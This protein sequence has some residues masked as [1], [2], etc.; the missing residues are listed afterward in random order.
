MHGHPLSFE[1]RIWTWMQ[2]HLLRELVSGRGEAK[3]GFRESMSRLKLDPCWTLPTVALIEPPEPDETVPDRRE[4]TERMREAAG[5]H[6][7]EGAALFASE[8]GRL[9]LIFSWPAKEALQAVHAA[10]GEW[11]GRAVPIGV[12]QP[13]SRLADLHRSHRQAAR[14]LSNKFYAGTGKILYDGELG[15]FAPPG[16]EAAAMERELGE[17]VRSGASDEAL[18]EAVE[19][20]YAALLR[21]GPVEIPAVH[22]WTVRLLAGTE[23]LVLAAAEKLGDYRRLE[24]L[25]VTKLETLQALKRYVADF[26]VRLR[27][28]GELNAKDSHRSIIKKTIHYM[29]QECQ[30]ASLNSVAR[31]VYM[32]PTYLSL[33]F[34]TNT[35]KTFIEHLTDIRIDKAKDML[36]KTHLKN[37]EVAERVG[38][39]DSRYFSQIFKKRVGL[40]PSEYRESIGS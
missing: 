9:G 23:K 6:L 39:Q 5:R 38:Y 28:V 19:R 13:G 31:K 34:K 3:P 18:A 30:N 37:Y 40:S 27:E 17:A 29:E 35:G 32:T 1:D 8:E 14:A 10:L 36:K 16:E 4:Y 20:F 24:I 22:E 26:L 11:I 15:R 7:P 33:L 21:D 12:G 25:S 2:D